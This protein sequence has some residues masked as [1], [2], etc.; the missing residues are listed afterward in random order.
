M[1]EK[2]YEIKRT[3]ISLPISIFEKLEEKR[4]PVSRS[5]YIREV[6]KAW[7]KEGHEL[8]DLHEGG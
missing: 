5:A 1:K 3:G 7:W 4:G 6:L 2:S 8:N